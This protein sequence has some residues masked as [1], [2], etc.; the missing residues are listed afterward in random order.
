MLKIHKVRKEELV[1]GLER[2]VDYFSTGKVTSLRD[3]VAKRSDVFIADRFLKALEKDFCRDLLMDTSDALRWLDTANRELS[4]DVKRK[5]HCFTFDSKALYDS[6]EPELVKETI[7]YVMD[8]WRPD[9]S[10]S[11]KNWILALIEFSLKASV[12]KFENP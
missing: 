1:P 8:T 5:V 9:W 11:L 3:G 4:A 6:L 12:A 2:L 7:K 10:E